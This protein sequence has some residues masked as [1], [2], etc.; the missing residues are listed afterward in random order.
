MASPDEIQ[1]A[2][3]QLVA[4]DTVHRARL[5]ASI[6]KAL[7]DIDTLQARYRSSNPTFGF[8]ARSILTEAAILHRIAS[9]VRTA[10]G[11]PSAATLNQ[12]RDELVQVEM[13]LV[14]ALQKVGST[15]TSI[16]VGQGSN[17]Q[18][19]AVI[20]DALYD[21]FTPA[22]RQGI[23]AAIVNYGIIPAF[24]GM[25][26]PMNQGDRK[27]W[28]KSTS[29]NNWSTIILGGGVMGSLALRQQDY[30][31]SFSCWPGTTNA[32]AKVTRTFR[33]HFDAFLPAVVSLFSTAWLSVQ[34]MGGMWD[35]GPGYSHD[36]LYPLLGTV[37]SLETAR[38]DTASARPAFLTDFASLSRQSA[39]SMIQM[40]IHF[41][42][43][44][45]RE[46]T[47]NDG[48]W[49]FTDQAAC[50]RLADFARQA[51]ASSA[52]RAAAWRARDRSPATWSS[53]HFLWNSLFDWNNPLTDPR[54]MSG[55]DPASI[56][57]ARY[58]HGARI[59]SS[60]VVRSGSNEHIAVWR[61]SWTDTNSTAVFLKG[62]D[63]RADRH[64]HLDT[65]D[66]LYDSLGVRWNADLGPPVGYPSY[67]PPAPASGSTS[68]QT[69]PK[70]ALGQNTLVVNP[71]RNDYLARA[72]P[73]TWLDVVQPDQAMDDGLSSHWAP[74]E[75]LNTSPASTIWSAKVNF[76]S[77]Y[78]RHGIRTAAQGAP[79]D[80]SR[81]F[82]WDRSSGALEIRDSLTFAQPGNE[83]FWY[84]QLP[85]TAHKP[86]YLSE[87]RVVLQAMR[88][89]T[90]VYLNL[91]LVSADASS[92]GGFKYGRIDENL[93]A[94]RPSD[95]L[96][97]GYDNAT[98][99]RTNL[100]KL[101]LRFTTTGSSL[102]VTVRAAPLPLLTGLSETAALIQLG[103]LEAQASAACG[104]PFNGTL[105]N[106]HGGT[107]LTAGT[108]APQF[109]TGGPEGTGSVL[110]D[111]VDD[112]LRTVIPLDFGDRITIAAWIRTTPGA[113]NIQTIAANA[114]SGAAN[115]FRFY[116]NNYN[117]SD[118][119]LVFE[120][121]NGTNQS[122]A[123]TTAGTI[124][125]GTWTHVAAVVDRAGG[126]TRL[127]VNGSLV[128]VQSLT[129]T[130]FTPD[131]TLRLGR[132]A[133][134]GGAFPFNGG[135]DDA[136]FLPRAMTA[137]E[138]RTLAAQSPSNRW[139]FQ[140]DTRDVTGAAAAA[141]LING[142]ALNSS[143]PRGG[144]Q[145]LFVDGNDDAVNLGA[146]NLGDVF[147]FSTW[148]RIQTGR[149][150]M[151]TLLFCR[152]AGSNSGTGIH[153]Y[154]NTWT[155]TDRKLHLNT[156]NGT[157]SAAIESA[158]GAVPFGEWVHVAAVIQ[159]S[160]GTARLYVN[161][162][163]VAS[164]PIR[165]DLPENMP[166]FLGSMGGGPYTQNLL[167]NLDEVRIDKRALSAAEIAGL[168]QRTG[169]APVIQ[170]VSIQP[171][172]PQPGQ[173]VTLS[174]NAFDPDTADTLRHAF[175]WGDG[176]ATS[177]TA[178]PI[179]PT[180]T[181]S[182]N[183]RFTTTALVD[184]GTFLVETSVPVDL[185][186][187]NTAPTINAA[188][189]L[190][191]TAGLDTQTLAITIGDAETP[192][193]N[194]TVTA[195]TG[196]PMMIPDTSLVLSGSGASRSLTT[197]IP[198]WAAGSVPVT[199]TVSDGSLS[200]SRILTLQITNNGWGSNW[201]T[202][203]ADELLP[204]SQ[205]SNWADSRT[206]VSGPDA[207]L[208]FFE[209]RNLPGINL[210]S[211]QDLTNPFVLSEWVLGGTGPASESGTLTL[212]GSSIRMV[213][214]G[215]GGP[216]RVRLDATAG[217]GFSYIIGVPVELSAPTEFSGN[218][219]A[220]F[221]FS[222]AISGSSAVT[223][224]GTST[225]NLGGSAAHTIAGPWNLA[226]G[227]LVFEPGLNNRLPAATQMNFTGSASWDLGGNQQTL[228]GLDL[229]HT[230]GTTTLQAAI[231]NGSLL[232]QTAGSIVI[233]P[234]TSNTGPV[235]NNTCLLDLS[236]LDSFSVQSGFDL[237]IQPKTYNT[238]SASA[239]MKLGDASTLAVKRLNISGMAGGGSH[240]GTL[241][242]GRENHIHADEISIGR[243]AR[244]NGIL[245]Y[246]NGTPVSS[247]TTIRAS[248]GTSRVQKLQL[249]EQWGGGGDNN[250]MADFTGGTLDA[251]VDLLEIGRATANARPCN[252]TFT[253]GT[254][255]GVLDANQIVL[256]M[257][258]S[259]ASGTITAGF[260]QNGGT[261][262]AGSLVL[263][264]TTGN[265]TPGV[266]AIY[267]INPGAVLECPSITS[268]AAG[269]TSASS[270]RT[271][272][273]NGGTLTP[274]GSSSSGRIAGKPAGGPLALDFT[275]G[276]TLLVP[277]NK[278]AVIEGT[279]RLSGSGFLRKTGSGRLV[280]NATNSTFTGGME[281]LGGSLDLT[282]DAA[283]GLPPAVVTADAFV[284]DGGTLTLNQGWQGNLSP[285]SPGTGHTTFPTLDLS[286]VSGETIQTHG[287]IGSLAIINQGASNHTAASIAFTAPDLPGGVPAA[288]TATMSGGK[289]TTA[290]LT[291]PGS[292]YTVPP[293]VFITLTGG[294]TV[295]TQPV[296]G[297]TVSIQG[298]LVLNPGHDCD[299]STPSISITGGGGNGTVF[300]ATSG[301]TGPITLDERRGL[302]IGPGGASVGAI[303][304][305]EIA[306]PISGTGDLTKILPGTLS[307]TGD[308]TNSGNTRVV[309][310]TLRLTRASLPDTASV[311][312]ESGANL[313]LDFDGSDSVDSLVLN[314]TTM[315]PGNYD[316]TNTGGLI[317]G[318][319]GILVAGSPFTLWSQAAFPG[320]IDSG[321]TGIRADPD[322]DGIPNGIEFVLGMDPT[323][324]GDG[325]FLP[326]LA[327]DGDVVR[328]TFRRSAASRTS[329]VRVEAAS[330]PGG[331]WT[332]LA[333]G[334]DGTSIA[335]AT[336][337]FGTGVDRV[338]VTL[339]KSSN[340]KL[341]LRLAVS[342]P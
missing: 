300:Q 155:T 101:A 241:E 151:Q 188:A 201:S 258:D 15:G 239:V 110:F 135:M 198:V 311:S 55:F 97:W 227:S 63:K 294:S 319:G 238:Q 131:G 229:I 129:R 340:T 295:A 235:T 170:G 303:G 335:E 218:G 299:G 297:L 268:G 255:G 59:E 29:I 186:P 147:T 245:R 107:A 326:S 149:S 246:R 312:I 139:T 137:L 54:G 8:D 180:K 156:S 328:F 250:A 57:L 60:P 333:D 13:D 47:H 73:K 70:R 123:F 76:S 206:P 228:A 302:A 217:T 92:N 249:G 141:T 337:G 296:I 49:S 305:H 93:P 128:T 148:T 330:A 314:G 266:S 325:G 264:S 331:T 3:D 140:N 23:A 35:E 116:V 322:G 87:N 231:S 120:T 288:A 285:V 261:V 313:R 154:A 199:L 27:W 221:L 71:A 121:A 301:T 175:L 84:W 161:G 260:Q 67:S 178:Q 74:L 44:S 187:P 223:K 164:G 75:N 122:K 309:T 113:S 50:Y 342:D 292:G 12:L 247:N 293:R 251:L 220:T 31:G 86:V 16:H 233:G 11:T 334:I 234:T 39:V 146:L 98:S 61:Q 6:S 88:D 45:R 204:W 219:D 236:T 332:T 106:A 243:S 207:I 83:V 103:L 278:T 53:L 133:P 230:T 125:A 321:T 90:P 95:S 111:G 263:G 212:T 124:P 291:N 196:D 145:S 115:G 237:S 1:R 200:T 317:T 307:L 242:L 265:L 38:R 184:D 167:G 271:L 159:R 30:D 202:A 99:Q 205:S 318:N 77:A 338:T 173:A 270:D 89:T 287:G 64:E 282:S 134:G 157:A 52:W 172:P 274:A 179:S 136:R 289:L 267:Q 169:S 100:R 315:P 211:Q 181:Y 310:G 284:I 68:Y 272:R 62:G 232:V 26:A 138:I 279:A 208:R 160:S 327:L 143:N 14:G 174:V 32:T 25:L 257:A 225:L 286:G 226:A 252:A 253:V 42:G 117:T 21:D 10:S 104:W 182:T 46:F 9:G 166:L 190:T 254:E 194:L 18:P 126:H 109:V 269:R 298:A 176:S 163:E 323:R 20:Y 58:F 28:A 24:N 94:S 304:S 85:G 276:G 214:P 306:G 320:I 329:P 144:I 308:R 168:A 193:D 316:A 277:L 132:M 341:F 65:G 80:P 336:D 150:S 114:A 162:S 37:S 2:V 81:T 192:A 17:I 40:G 158:A 69:Y 36:F 43:P 4:G 118:G 105:D 197:S 213:A 177:W 79:S 283:C 41:A 273:L 185:T 5:D 222:G 324:P 339:P 78:A 215:S 22:Q 7:T 108:G 248:N 280:C 224:S 19:L 183:A 153:L 51:D 290:T 96:L 203:R 195:T 119:A 72:V 244:T 82:T 189:T 210:Q 91:E 127:F 130:D 112:E 281:I 48:N 34:D 191:G 259:T 152:P 240:S 256:G 66:F 102:D 209:G 171:T 216:A 262:R 33:E 142:A 275:A 56:P 165:T